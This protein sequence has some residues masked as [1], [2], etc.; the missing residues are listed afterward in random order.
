MSNQE[1]GVLTEDKTAFGTC[2]NYFEGLW[3][4]AQSDLKVKCIDAWETELKDYLV[5]HGNIFDMGS[6]NDYGSKVGF[7]PD[8]ETLIPPIFS[9]QQ[10]SFVKFVGSSDNRVSHET[11]IIKE[12][13]NSECHKVLAYPRNRR[14]INVSKGSIM[15]IARLEKDPVDIL[16][17]GRAIAKEY[18][19]GRDDASEEDINRRSRRERWSHYIRVRNAEFVAGTMD[20]GISLYEMMN[21]LGSDAFEPTK[22]IS[23]KGKEIQIHI[24]QTY[25]IQTLGSHKRAST[26]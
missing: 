17:F 5:K 3:D 26:G 19:E 11:P 24:K 22:K 14:P 25:D 10:K 6:L 18:E 9:E 21:E 20:E 1:F 23:L 16:I 7:E 4:Q 13:E 2:H 15:F 12:L 8:T